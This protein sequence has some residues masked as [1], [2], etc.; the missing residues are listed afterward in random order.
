MADSLTLGT[1]VDAV[2]SPIEHLTTCRKGGQK[3]SLSDDVKLKLAQDISS[4]L[5]LRHIVLIPEKRNKTYVI[6]K[7]LALIN[8]Y[9][10]SITV[11]KATLNKWLVD[12]MAE[13]VDWEAELLT[14]EKDVGSKKS[15]QDNMP[16]DSHK[17]AWVQLMRDIRALT[18]KDRPD[19]GHSKK[20]CK[21]NGLTGKI[22][23]PSLPEPR[24]SIASTVRKAA[25]KR[26]PPCWKQARSSAATC[27]CTCGWGRGGDCASDEPAGSAH[28]RA[29][30]DE[31]QIART[32][33]ACERRTARE[34]PRA[35]IQDCRRPRVQDLARV[36]AQD[37]ACRTA[38]AQDR[39]RAQGARARACAQAARARPSCCLLQFLLLSLLGNPL[40]PRTDFHNTLSV[41]S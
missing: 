34:G 13:C 27:S 7:L 10:T 4:Q 6:E 5:D 40:H 21:L 30:G 25:M 33:R 36:R 9:L 38:R 14:E 3:S 16:D 26:W 19:S 37:R 12:C 31:E 20:R 1:D 35:R 32:G 8:E 11:N 29:D 23:T 18:V 28:A 15:R 17:L 2:S 41:H 24:P 22:I 39:A